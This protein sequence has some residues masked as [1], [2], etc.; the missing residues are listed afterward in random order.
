[1]FVRLKVEV[2]VPDGPEQEVRDC[3][4]DEEGSGI[5]V[6]VVVDVVVVD[7]IDELRHSF[8]N[9]VFVLSAWSLDIPDE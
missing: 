7:V 2:L 5:V 9:A 1:L 3:E 6:V 4:I 8:S